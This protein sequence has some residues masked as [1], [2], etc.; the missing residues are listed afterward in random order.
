M[1]QSQQNQIVTLYQNEIQSN[2]SKIANLE[3]KLIQEQKQKKMVSLQKKI[4]LQRNRLE[5]QKHI[6]DNNKKILQELESLAKI[7][8]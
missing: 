5:K 1:I 8:S 4:F 6:K 3:E 7:I 2:N